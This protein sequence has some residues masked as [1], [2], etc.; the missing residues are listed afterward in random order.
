MILTDNA[1]QT[2]ILRFIVGIPGLDI[3]IT[4]AI[5]VECQSVNGTVGP[6]G[7]DQDSPSSCIHCRGGEQ[8]HD[9]RVFVVFAGDHDPEVYSALGHDGG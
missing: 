7:K 3:E 8:G 6:A 9:D 1:C 5:P 2:V 4:V